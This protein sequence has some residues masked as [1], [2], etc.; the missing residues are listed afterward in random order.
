MAHIFSMCMVCILQDYFTWINLLEIKIIKINSLW[1]LLLDI[2][3]DKLCAGSGKKFGAS[4]AADGSPIT[5]LGLCQPESPTLSIST[6][7]QR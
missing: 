2:K 3:Y 5:I 1:V 6:F 4:S 7:E